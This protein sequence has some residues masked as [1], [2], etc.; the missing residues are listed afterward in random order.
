[1]KETTFINGL[2]FFYL[3]L[4]PFIFGSSY[5][6]LPLIP[7]AYLAREN[8]RSYSIF[9]FGLLGDLYFSVLPF[10]LYTVFLLSAL[11]V[12]RRVQRLIYLD[13]LFALGI[14]VFI[15]SAL[16]NGCQALYFGESATFLQKEFWYDPFKEGL[17]ALFG[18]TLPRLALLPKE[19][20]SLRIFS[21]RP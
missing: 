11:W 5:F 7:A 6:S 2:T 19:E 8:K 3:L 4:F 18:Y 17:F 21:F 16:M 13:D 10:G 12:L 1:M 20:R 9:G 14:H 15:L